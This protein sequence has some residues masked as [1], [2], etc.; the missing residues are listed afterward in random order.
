M[1]PARKDE[2]GGGVELLDPPN[3]EPPEGDAPGV[4]PLYTG[5]APAPIASP[6]IL[7]DCYFELTGV[8]LRCLVKHLEVVPTTTQVTITS[9]CAET[10]YPGM[11]KWQ[12]KVTFHQSY[13]VGA[14]YATL[15]AA[16]AAYVASGQPAVFKVRPYYSRAQAANNPVISGFAIPQPFELL[17][18]DA[19]AAS[20]VQIAWALTGPPTVDTTGVTATG[21]TAGTPGY[22]TP[23][24]ASVPA[25]LAALT[26]IAASP[27]TAWATGTYV[28][29][30][31]LLGA[32]WTGSAWA[33]GKA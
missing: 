17:V 13:D 27:S 7:T 5:D 15:Q 4:E 28:L 22:Y 6:L 23:S 19:G 12:L 8:N 20:E 29:T 24:G 9:F 32:H 10:D 1:T 30:A 11:S 18:G 21:A 26:G 2:N 16:Y 14:V 33:A 25:N 31:D 3:G